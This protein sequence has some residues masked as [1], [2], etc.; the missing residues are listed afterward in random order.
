MGHSAMKEPWPDYYTC[1]VMLGL[2]EDDIHKIFFSHWII[3]P[4][5]VFLNSSGSNRWLISMSNCKL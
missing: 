1:V 3:P 2:P 4:T 5:S